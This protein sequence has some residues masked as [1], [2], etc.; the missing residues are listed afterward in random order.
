MVTM[1]SKALVLRPGETGTFSAGR[2]REAALFTAVQAVG[3]P[4]LWDGQA[5][6]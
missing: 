3:L 1:R 4:G 6:L 2:G 5:M